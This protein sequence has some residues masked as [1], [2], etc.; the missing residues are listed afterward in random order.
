MNPTPVPLLIVDDDPVSAQLVRQLVLS[1]GGEFPCAPQW[2]ESAEA[3]MT[4]VTQ[5]RYQ[6]MLLDYNLPGADGLQVLA[7]IRD[8]P[9]E[10][11]PAVIMLTGSGNEQIAVEAMKRGAQDYL[12]KIG[13]EAPPLLRALRSALAQKQLA[14]QVARYHAQT[15]ADLE[16]ARHLQQSLLPDRYPGFPRSASPA[17][18]SLRF[19]H[20]FCPAAELAGDFFRVL[21][22]SDTRAGVFI[23]DVM[24]HGV[25]AALV[26]A[27]V[28]GL[29]DSTARRVA[30]PGRFLGEMNRRLAKLL[31]PAGSTMFAT[32]FY[33]V[34]DVAEGR[35]SYATAGHPPPLHLQR[36]SG[37]AMA[38]RVPARAGPALGLFDDAA[39]VDGECPLAAGDVIL[40]FT[41]GL[42]EVT[43]AAGQEEYGQ[44][45]LL[46]A[47][48]RHMNLPPPELCDALMAEVRA[49]AGETA[50]SDDVC[51]LS[52]EVARLDT[53]SGTAGT[54]RNKATP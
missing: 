48:H 41:D 27:M 25:R 36:R 54:E 43:D 42:V 10:R 12:L 17:E 18:S 49:F 29:L 51:L 33:L 47:A 6:L 52:V 37:Q 21:P 46:A 31:K 24:G 39:Y 14:D 3:A 19:C 45:R 38:L 35:L 13:L 44:Q 30:D 5:S 23:C 28:R 9:P 16:M 8:L 22:L 15:H 7:Q 2:V 4:A 34:A 50:L 32:A 40:L 20:R 11:Q 1:L 26:T 53:G